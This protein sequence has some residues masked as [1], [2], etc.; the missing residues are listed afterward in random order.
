MVLSG[1]LKP[2]ERVV[3]GTLEKSLGVGQAT[4]REALQVR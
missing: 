4:V 2:G 3:E 1:E